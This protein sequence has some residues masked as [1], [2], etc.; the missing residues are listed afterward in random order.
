MNDCTYY[1]LVSVRELVYLI[2]PILSLWMYT[3][4]VKAVILVCDFPHPSLQLLNR[5]KF[6]EP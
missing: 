4:D 2:W 3:A 5:W 6:N 1:R